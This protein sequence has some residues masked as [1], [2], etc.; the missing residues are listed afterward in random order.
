MDKRKAKKKSPT[1]KRGLKERN[2]GL[3]ECEETLRKAKK[4]KSGNCQHLKARQRLRT[5]IKFRKSKR[6]FNQEKTQHVPKVN[7][8]KKKYC[9]TNIVFWYQ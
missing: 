6:G 9:V 2:H 8:R 3:G 5:P 4:K 1:I 7:I